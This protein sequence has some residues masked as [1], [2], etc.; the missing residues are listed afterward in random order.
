VL[1]VDD[2]SFARSCHPS[3]LRCGE[4]ASVLVGSSNRQAVMLDVLQYLITA[5]SD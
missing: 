1:Y 2:V 4:L 5:G 3:L